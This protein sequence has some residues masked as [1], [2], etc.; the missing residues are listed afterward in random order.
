MTTTTTQLMTAEQFHDWVNQSENAGKHYELERGRVIEVS[1][2]G[3][4]HGFVAVNIG[5]ILGNYTFERRKGYV[6][7]NDTGVIWERGPDTVR[8][9]DLIYY[10][11]KSRGRDLSPRYSDVVPKLVV[12]V[13]SPND[14]TGKVNKRIAQFLKWG[15]AVVWLA[16]PDDSTITVYRPD[17]AHKV[18]SAD[19]ELTDEELLPGFR[20]RVGDFFILPGEDEEEA[21]PAS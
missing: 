6:C 19:E 1:R 8:G 17:R 13:L 14:R 9:P 15:V 2:P 7:G 18:Y 20:C 12:E 11:K 5:R 10:D 3:E 4:L 16:D 21:A